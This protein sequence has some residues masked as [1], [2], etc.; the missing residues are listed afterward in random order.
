MKPSIRLMTLIGVFCGMLAVGLTVRSDKAGNVRTVHAKDVCSLDTLQG[1]YLVTGRGDA[2]IGSMDSSFPRVTLAVWNFDGQG[3]MSGFGTAS[4]GGK[5][6]R[7]TPLTATYTL[8]SDCTG[9]LTFTPGMPGWELFVTS[10][11]KVGQ[12]LNL[13][14]GTIGTRS[15]ERR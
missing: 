12:T 11:G 14:E 6:S 3:N 7:R 9:T 1:S 4:N 13:N 5:I 8:D 10:D 2:P 15:F